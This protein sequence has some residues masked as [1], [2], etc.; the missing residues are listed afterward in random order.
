MEVRRSF[1]DWSDTNK[2]T[3]EIQV[4]KELR[5]RQ[6]QEKSRNGETLTINDTLGK[7]LHFFKADN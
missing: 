4:S 7:I 6:R 2:G 1:S 3:H 5:H